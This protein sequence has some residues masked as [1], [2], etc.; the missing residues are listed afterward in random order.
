MSNSQKNW[1]APSSLPIIGQLNDTVDQVADDWEEER[2][3]RAAFKA[4]AVGGL[5]ALTAFAL[6][7]KK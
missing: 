6:F 7:Q 5:F 2:Y 3:F 4:V 1:N